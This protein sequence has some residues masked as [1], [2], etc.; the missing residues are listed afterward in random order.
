M[1]K[2]LGGYGLLLV[3]LCAI[4]SVVSAIGGL[5]FF[6]GLLDYGHEV[7][8]SA[9]AFMLALRENRLND[10]YA[11]LTPALQDKQSKVNF[12]QAFTGNSIKD[13][14]FSNFSIQNDLG[15]VAGTV[16][17]KVGN[18]FVA[19]QLVNHQGKWAIT[20]YNLGTLGWIGT[21]IDP[22]D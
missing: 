2:R 9:N 10:A 16:T 12:R 15:Y 8:D 3:F 18:H 21:V 20:G 7:G 1:M 6:S 13:W 22:S 4:C 17:D 11:M 5:K 19:F 14:K